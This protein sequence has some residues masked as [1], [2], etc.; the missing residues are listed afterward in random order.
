M[1]FV[2]GLCFVMRVLSVLSSFAIISPGKRA[3]YFNVI[4]F[5]VACDCL[6]SLPL[7][8]GAVGWS[9]VC[10]CGISWS[11]SLTCRSLEATKFSVF[12]KT[13]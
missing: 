1:G 6:Y 12:I 9:V 10:D 11:Y 8:Y 13:D 3:S 4:V 7:P 2:L 5:L